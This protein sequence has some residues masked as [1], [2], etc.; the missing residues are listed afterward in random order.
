MTA[1]WVLRR[2][3]RQ[4]T[5]QRGFLVASMGAFLLLFLIGGT[6][7]L[8]NRATRGW[9]DTVGQGVNVLVFLNDET[10]TDQAEQMVALLRRTPGVAQVQQVEPAQALARLRDAEL[11]SSGSTAWMD[12]LDPGYFPRSL[13]LALTPTSDVSQR[14]AQLAERLRSLPGVVYVDAM[15]DGVARL[16]AWIQFGQRL[17][18][19]VVFALIAAATLFLIGMVVRG[20]ETRCQ[21]AQIL[22]MLG[23][24]K[25]LARMP[26]NVLLAAAGLVGASLGLLT[27]R[28][29]WPPALASVERWLG[30]VPSVPPSLGLGESALCLVLAPAL[31]WVSGYL[32]TPVC[33]LADA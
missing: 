28:L 5:R 32:S 21:D 33:D 1:A 9:L 8:A 25:K 27:L 17:G 18:W 11:R 23:E 16:G 3:R 2:T 22:L 6:A 20:R 24:T 10:T 30:L 12:D 14:S 7:V 29:A 13:E 15:S 31:G 19:V 4:W 26:S